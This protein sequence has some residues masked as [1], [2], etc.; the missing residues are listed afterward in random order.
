[1]AFHDVN[2]FDVA[3]D[4][5]HYSYDADNNGVEHERVCFKCAKFKVL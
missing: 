4:K 1:V 2:S 3:D 5:D